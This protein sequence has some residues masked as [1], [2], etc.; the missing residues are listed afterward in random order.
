MV[1]KKVGEYKV[2]QWGQRKRRYKTTKCLKRDS[3]V[4]NSVPEA[5]GSAS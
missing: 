1:T 4:S 5:G 3:S 2:S